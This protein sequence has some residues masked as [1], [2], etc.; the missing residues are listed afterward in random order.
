MSHY[1]N[2]LWRWPGW[3][4]WRISAP[5][6]RDSRDAMRSSLL[7]ILA[8]AHQERITV[9]PLLSHLAESHRGLNRRALRRLVKR[10][11]SGA[12]LMTAIEQT[13]EVLTNRQMLALRFGSQT[14]LLD[15]TYRDLI[16][17]SKGQALS[18]SLQLRQTTFYM[19]AMIAAIMIVAAFLSAVIMPVILEL[20]GGFEPEMQPPLVFRL[21]AMISAW[22][23][24]VFIPA[25]IAMIPLL[26]LVFDS[27]AGRWL[28]LN[29]ATGRWYWM[30]QLLRADMM[31]MLARSSGAGR[32]VPAALSVLARHHFDKQI[33]HQL[34]FARNEVEQGAEVWAS[35]CDA[36]LLSPAE[37]DVIRI[38]S[39]NESR[40][41]AMRRLAAQKRER[42]VEKAMS[43]AQW[44]QTL[45]I[46][47]IALIVLAITYS[48]FQF[49][50]SALFI[51]S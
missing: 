1:T 49:L 10:L 12:S 31:E 41:L 47:G 34:L 36:K 44:F 30:G 8:V 24:P 6:P 27:A 45:T 15:S 42:V 2:H 7:Q 9:I 4:R 16:S 11:S 13:P 21:T 25:F 50:T 43:L 51:L 22:V 5:W 17:E 20:I 26:P 32:P 35:L 38:A 46:I 33:R 29:L 19:G 37:A 40:I 18:I 48:V 14:G 39:T 28:K 3:Y 23:H